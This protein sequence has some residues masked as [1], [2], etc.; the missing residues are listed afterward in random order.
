M[1]ALLFPFPFFLFFF[2]S[3]QWIAVVELQ[4]SLWTDTHPRVWWLFWL[5]WSICTLQVTILS[6]L[7]RN[8]GSIGFAGVPSFI[9]L[10]E[11]R[12]TFIEVL[13]RLQLIS[14][15]MPHPSSNT[16]VESS[17]PTEP[18]SLVKTAL[19]HTE[20]RGVIRF[21]IVQLLFSELRVCNSASL[22]FGE[23]DCWKYG[24]KEV[25]DPGQFFFVLFFCFAFCCS[26]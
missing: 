18:I 15:W 10:S 2:V 26:A 17:L 13:N 1:T 5:Q 24:K 21:F 11:S 20:M 6:Y 16:V 25:G 22:L 8:I 9:K 3:A 12:N 19:A 7:F 4:G 14:V 23:I